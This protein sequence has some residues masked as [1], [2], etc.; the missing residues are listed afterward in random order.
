MNLFHNLKL[1]L[2]KLQALKKETIQYILPM[3]REDY[4]L[5]I[6]DKH[7]LNV[8]IVRFYHFYKQIGMYYWDMKQR[9]YCIPVSYFVLQLYSINS[10]KKRKNR[11]VKKSR[12]TKG[13]QEKLR[14]T[15]QKKRKQYIY[16]YL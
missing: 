6:L 14:K 15:K 3:Y 16:V 4:P 11:N 9:N 10:S 5:F 8:P 1:K 7:T 13:T 2:I 12:K